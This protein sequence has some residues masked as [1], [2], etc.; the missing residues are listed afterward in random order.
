MRYPRMLEVDSLSNNSNTAAPL[1]PAYK[2]VARTESMQSKASFYQ[3][4]QLCGSIKSDD[5][6][7]IAPS[8]QTDANKYI[9]RST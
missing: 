1:P 6:A 8:S 9:R 2:D 3:Q 4:H 5:V 7:T